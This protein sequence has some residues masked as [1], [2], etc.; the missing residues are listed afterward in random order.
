MSMS[1]G[2]KAVSATWAARAFSKLVMIIPVKVAETISSSSQGMR[3]LNRSK[4]VA[5]R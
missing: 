4:V 3:C 1:M 2:M 5:R